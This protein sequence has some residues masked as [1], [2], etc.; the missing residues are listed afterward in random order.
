MKPLDPALFRGG[1]RSL[2][3]RGNSFPVGPQITSFTPATGPAGVILATPGQ[4]IDG[5]D[6]RGHTLD[7][8]ADGICLRNCILN[9]MGYHTI[10][11]LTRRGLVLELILFD[12]QKYNGQHSEFVYSEAPDTIVRNSLFFDCPTDAVNLCGGRMERNAFFGAAYQTGAHADALSVH[13]TVGPV[14]VRENYIDFMRRV[15]EQ[16]NSPNSCI[17]IVGHFGDIRDVLIENNVLIGGG[18]NAYT[19]PA[20]PHN[21]VVDN[22]R[23]LNN[24]MGLTEY[25]DKETQFIMPGDHGTNFVATGNTLFS[26]AP[27]GTVSA[28]GSLVPIPPP[29]GGNPV[30]TSKPVI[31]GGTKVGELAITASGVWDKPQPDWSWNWAWTLAGAVVPDAISFKMTPQA[32]G[33]LVVTVTVTTPQGG[34]TVVSSDPVQVVGDPVVPPADVPFTAAE[35][36]TL[37][38]GNAAIAAVL[39]GKP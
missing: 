8:Q 30:C 17:K 10:Y 35:V 3:M 1:K 6:F 32:P 12:G 27:E 15:P 20:A 19:G 33:P 5:I 14:V 11:N 24:L 29:T 18:F 34:K 38:T 21:G 7:I 36:K 16:T 28:G 2:T 23:F 25:G 13:K 4:V 31:G 39:A 9:P 26:A 37:K 22:V